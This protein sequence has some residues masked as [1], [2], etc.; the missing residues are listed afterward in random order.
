[1]EVYA[2]FISHTDH[3]I[4]RVISFLEEIGELDNTLLFVTSDN[5]ASAE[6]GPRG[7]FAAQMENNQRSA[8]LEE[9]LAAID[10][11][12]DPT[13]FPHYSYGWAWAGNTPL[14]RWKRFVHEGGISDALIVHWPERITAKGEIRGQYAHVVDVVP[15][16]LE[17]LGLEAPSEIEESPSRRSTGQL[18]PHLRRRRGADPKDGPIL[19]DARLAGH[20]ARRLEGGDPSRSRA[21]C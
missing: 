2:G 20:L 14:R 5:G 11:W 3:H 10:R 6:G 18:R 16:V 15:T 4:G 13:T 12:G 8:T 17:S 7:S 21:W 1:M 19:R 9:N